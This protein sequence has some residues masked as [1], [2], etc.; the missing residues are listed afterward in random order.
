MSYQYKF[1]SISQL[2]FW[3]IDQVKDNQHIKRCEVCG[4]YYSPKR[5][6]AKYCSS[7]CRNKH[8]NENLY[9]AE[10]ES[11]NQQEDWRSD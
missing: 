10:K 6:T 1:T 7:T 5:S 4:K 3:A 11:K 8:S 9:F 2:V